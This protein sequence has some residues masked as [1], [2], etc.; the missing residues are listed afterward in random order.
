[1]TT[2]YQARLKA[3]ILE[4]IRE[5]GPCLAS[6]IRDELNPRYK[7]NLTVGSVSAYCKQLVGAGHITA[8]HERKRDP[9]TYEAVS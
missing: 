3:D 1:M 6:S 4:Y 2:R 5:N 7:G 9:M 8:S